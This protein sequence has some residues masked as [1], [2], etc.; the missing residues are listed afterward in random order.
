MY[1]HLVDEFQWFFFLWHNWSFSRTVTLDI[2]G[3]TL[4]W[5]SVSGMLPVHL[6]HFTKCDHSNEFWAAVRSNA[7]VSCPTQWAESLNQADV[8]GGISVA[9]KIDWVTNTRNNIDTHCGKI[10][11]LSKKVNLW[12]SLFFVQFKFDSGEDSIK[13]IKI[14][15]L[16]K[17]LTFR[18]VWAVLYF[19]RH[20]LEWQKLHYYDRSYR[21]AVVEWNKSS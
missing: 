8:G 4:P 21:N 12:I 20:R 13:I 6:L 15:F 14:E 1:S 11:F 2:L 19:Y 9:S 10:Q 16:D 5:F 18:I 7:R 3:C 17:N